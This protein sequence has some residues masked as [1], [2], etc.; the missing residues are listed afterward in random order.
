MKRQIPKCIQRVKGQN[1]K[2][3]GTC[4]SEERRKIQDRNRCVRTYN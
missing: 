4:S 2:L 3:T 1:H